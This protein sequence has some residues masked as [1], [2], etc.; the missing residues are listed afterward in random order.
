MNLHFIKYMVLY[1]ILTKDSN[2][3]D[4]CPICLEEL[5][6]DITTHTCGKKYHEKCLSNWDKI[7]KFHNCPICRGILYPGCIFCLRQIQ[8]GL[9][10]QFYTN[11]CQGRLCILCY[12]FQ[13]DLRFKEK[14]PNCNKTGD[15]PVHKKDIIIPCVNCNENKA[16]YNV[17]T[18]CLHYY[19]KECVN[20]K[21]TIGEK[22]QFCKA[23]LKARTWMSWLY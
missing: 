7:S 2:N 9:R 15:I 5:V 18:K 6:T 17:S 10:F 12:E 22:C 21:V 8:L 3:Y 13:K 23:F 14:C 16:N 11:C 4:E 1:F 20:H 19:C